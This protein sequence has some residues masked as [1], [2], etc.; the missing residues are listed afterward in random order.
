MSVVPLPL[1]RHRVDIDVLVSSDA[2]FGLDVVEE[3]CRSCRRGGHGHL[4]GG[5][6]GL[7]LVEFCPC[8]LY[9]CGWES[10]MADGNCLAFLEGSGHRA[11]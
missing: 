11:D 1:A 2:A 3:I 9:L 5:R 7:N 6:Y 8:G 10:K 4:F